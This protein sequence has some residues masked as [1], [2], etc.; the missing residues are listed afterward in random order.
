MTLGSLPTFCSKICLGAADTLDVRG[1]CLNDFGINF[2]LVK[3]EC[4][5]PGEWIERSPDFS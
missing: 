2:K 3:I 4:E 1:L 5:T